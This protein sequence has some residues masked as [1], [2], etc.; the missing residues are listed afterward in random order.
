MRTLRVYHS[1]IFDSYSN[2]PAQYSYRFLFNFIILLTIYIYICTDNE[3]KLI[4]V[5]VYKDTMSCRFS[6]K[7]ISNNFLIH[8]F[9]CPPTLFICSG[10]FLRENTY[11]I[12]VLH[13][14]LLVY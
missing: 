5:C 1:T 4:C 9:H 7:R 8:F 10:E 14:Q 2:F 6:L 11:I 13:I 3:A 12:H